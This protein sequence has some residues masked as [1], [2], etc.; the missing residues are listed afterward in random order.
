[1]EQFNITSTPGFAE[2]LYKNRATLLLSTYQAGRVFVLSSTNGEQL[3]VQPVRFR[4]P[5]GIALHGTRMA[6]ATLNRIE[7]YA[8]NETVGKNSPMSFQKFDRFY[9]PRMGYV[10]GHLDLH[11]IHLHDKGVFAI[12]TQF[13]CI[14]SFSIEHHF[15]P[16]WVPPFIDAMVPEDRCHL[17]GMAVKDHF[18]SYVTAL[19]Q[20]NEKGSWRD[21]I[22]TDGI[23]IDVAQNKILFSDLAMPHSPRFIN[24]ELYLIESAKG[25]LIKINPEKQTKSVV[26]RTAAFSRGLAHFNGI[27]AIGRSKARETSKT[28]KKL[29]EDVRKKPAGIDLMELSSGQLLGRMHFGAVVDEIYD[30]QVITGPSVGMYGMAGTDYYEPITTPDFS[31]WRKVDSGVVPK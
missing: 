1:M 21:G 29:P 5:M 12:N 9:V 16:R 6:V 24:D 15:T 25:D 7:I 28:F 27:A 8:G 3:D 17:N 13:N 20:G 22:T 10:S 2:V 26:G 30:V 4:K 11:D 31:F 18:P 19:G 23:L 14:A